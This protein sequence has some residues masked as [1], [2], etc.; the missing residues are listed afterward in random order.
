MNAQ[1]GTDVAHGQS[2]GVQVGS[3]LNVHGVT[4]T[5]QCQGRGWRPWLSAE[6]DRPR[7]IRWSLGCDVLVEVEEVTGIVGSLDLD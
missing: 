7:R 3:T 1:F 5:A 2:P 6:S 4:V